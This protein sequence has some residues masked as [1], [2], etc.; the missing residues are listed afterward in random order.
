MTNDS[1]VCG[2]Y[3]ERIIRCFDREEY[4]LEFCNHGRFRMGANTFYKGIESESRKDKDEG[5]GDYRYF[6][7]RTTSLVSRDPS[8]PTE[9]IEEDGEVEAS[10]ENGSPVYLFCCTVSD[11]MNYT[12]QKFG[13]FPVEI[14]DPRQLAHFIDEYIQS[15]SER[16][17]I[18]G[19]MVQYTRGELL[20]PGIDQTKACD[21]SYTQKGS[22]FREDQEFRYCAISTGPDRLWINNPPEFLPIDLN[23]NADFLSPLWK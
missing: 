5:R 12:T 19:Q 15:Q 1:K 8:I 3:P 11:D 6:G 2:F 16:F 14:S 4:A 10:V 17:L 9:W 13:K 23:T 7:R 21:L 20:A 18:D 22:T